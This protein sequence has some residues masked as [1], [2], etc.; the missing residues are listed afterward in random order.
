MK[1]HS[2]QVVSKGY[3]FLE[4]DCTTFR[5]SNSCRNANAVYCVS[6]LEWNMRTNGTFRFYKLF[7]TQS[8]QI[9]I[10]FSRDIPG[11]DFTGIKIHYNAEIIPALIYVKSLT[12]TRL[13]AFWLKYC[14][15]WLVHSLFSLR[16]WAW[17][18]FGVDIFGNGSEFIR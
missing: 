8:W 5:E 15:R 18:G 2:Q 6:R 1:K 10:R 14:W 17:K 13:G 12:Q 16:L 7:W 3:P 11:D 4:N 9:N